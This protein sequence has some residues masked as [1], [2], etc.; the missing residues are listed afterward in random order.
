I[1]YIIWA[2]FLAV[3]ALAQGPSSTLHTDRPYYFSGEYLFYSFCNSKLPADSVIARVELY[4]NDQEVDSYFINMVSQCGQGYFKLPFDL[5]TDN[6]NLS[7]YLYDETDFLPHKLID[8][9]ISI[10]NDADINRLK[11]EPG[12]NHHP[13][14]ESKI[15]NDTVVTL[16]S[17]R[18][19]G[20]ITINLPVTKEKINRI[21]V[22]VRDHIL[23]AS[24]E[25][26]LQNA[27]IDSVPTNPLNSIPFSGVRKVIDPGPIRNPL[28]FTFD[29]TNLS[30]VG[31]KVNADEHFNLELKPFY[32]SK[33]L[34]F[35]DYVG[36][37]IQINQSQKVQRASIEREIRIDSSALDHLRVY[38]Q[39]KQ[40]N[41]LFKQLNVTPE[42]SAI[43]SII[44]E[45]KPS[46]YIDVQDYTIRGT[47]V[48]LFKEITT[49][50]KFR[51]SGA[52]NFNAK[53]IYEFNGITKFYSRSPLFIVNGRA[54]RDGNFIAKLPLQEIA[55][56]TIYSDYE[57]LEHLSPMAHGGIVFVDML[58]PN[59][60]LP[61]Q[62]ALPS[63]RIQ[64]IQPPI[65]YPLH[66]T[67]FDDKPAIGSLLFWS[68]NV[69]IDDDSITIELMSG[70][71]ISEYLVE[72]VVY[73]KDGESKI[74]R[75]KI[76]T[77]TNV[78]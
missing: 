19:S 57:F 29:P 22:S 77:T 65:E 10:F 62:Y 64:G 66:P 51:S 52:G 6:Y 7:I 33:P 2:L 78:N 47:T 58:D 14:N 21:S 76:A 30:F 41:R 32:G 72:V 39:E 15:N 74:I 63:I 28:L 68:P 45:G 37:E 27:D 70:D 1:K 49:N 40:I 56:I 34:S 59:Y 42:L 35:L 67:F 5:P 44:K 9:K 69:P 4:S 43:A 54:T 26:T 17:R 75:R 25:G 11:A 60:V 3:N 71:I 36:N 31:S 23:Y 18:Q 55:F 73:L 38:H 53:M 12:N 16:L 50:L 61:D 24:P 48:D 46:S 20:K 13:P 8:G